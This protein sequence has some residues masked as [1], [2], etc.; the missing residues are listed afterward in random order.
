M[1]MLIGFGALLLAAGVAGCS[2]SWSISE[3]SES[4]G[5]SSESSS[6]KDGVGKAKIPYRDDIANMTLSVAG[7]NFTSANYMAAIGRIAAQRSISDWEGEKATYYGIGKG[8]KKAGIAKEAI[9][10]QAFLTGVLGSRSEARAWI[11]DGYRY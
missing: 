3:S 8:L 7:S 9:G 4:L 11:E 2:I 6:P 5:S 1:R 10:K